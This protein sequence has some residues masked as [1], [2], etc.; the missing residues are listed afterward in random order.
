M[1]AS[2]ASSFAFGTILPV[3]SDRPPGRGAMTVFPVVGAV[4]GALAAVVVWAGGYAFGPGSPITGL[5]AVAAL[6]AATRGLHID[7]VAD[8]ADGLGCARPA[9]QAL[10][11]M[12]EGSTGPFGVVAVVLV[13]GLQATTFPMLGA[14]QIVLAVC[15]GRV[16]A[17]VACRR[18]VPAAA[19]SMLG[20]TV[21]GSQ[22]LWVA[23]AWVA[24]LFA[25][26]I[27]AGSAPWHGPVAVALALACAA[28][29][30]KRCVSRLGGITGDVLGAVIEWTTA[31]VA[32]ALTALTSG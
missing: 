5:L 15:A 26:A 14:G 18:S 19:G 21:A 23:A 12:R 9:P 6:L 25:G 17:V 32:V 4:L 1:I 29:L 8:T 28:M 20:A 27:P 30:V 3:S 11:V 13:I 31:L 22:P 10:Q 2:L 7:G 24:A 16:A